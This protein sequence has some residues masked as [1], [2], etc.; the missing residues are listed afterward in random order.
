MYVHFAVLKYLLVFVIVAKRMRPQIQFF[1]RIMKNRELKTF[2]KFI[3]IPWVYINHKSNR[4]W[5]CIVGLCF[6]TTPQQ[7]LYIIRVE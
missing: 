3:K 2:Y 4:N 6:W 1:E 7:K 5:N